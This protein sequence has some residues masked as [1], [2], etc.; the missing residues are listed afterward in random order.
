MK[1]TINNPNSLLFRWDGRTGLFQGGQCTRFYAFEDELGNE[2][3]YEG[4]P[5]PV[6][7]AVAGSFPLADVIGEANVNLLVAVESKDAEIKSL[8][9]AAKPLQD[10]LDDANKKIAVLTEQLAAFQPPSDKNG[11]P[12]I[13]TMMQAQLALLSAGLLDRVDEAIASI[14]GDQGRAA[15]IEW[16][17][18]TNV[19]RDHALINAMQ[20]ALGLTSEQI[21]A[22]F[23]AAAKL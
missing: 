17:K 12:Q 7:E 11:V 22:L 20:D 4:K 18:A 6:G 16:S 3:A 14:P 13:V 1:P 2:T 23:I 15:Q 9:D 5:I 8:K 10:A 19:H 21:D